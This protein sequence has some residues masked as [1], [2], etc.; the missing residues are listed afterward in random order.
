MDELL[1]GAL[2]QRYSLGL[3]PGEFGSLAVILR[4]PT[5]V[6]KALRLPSGAIVIGLGKW[7]E[8]S[9]GQLSDLLRRAALQY[10]LELRD[11]LAASPD[12]GRRHLRRWACRCC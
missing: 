6:Q 7:G 5:A 12:D 3:Y 2:S 4:K 1:R 9:T 8:L 11:G 10:V